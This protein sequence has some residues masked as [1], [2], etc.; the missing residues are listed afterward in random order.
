MMSYFMFLEHFFWSLLNFYIGVVFTFRHFILIN[1]VFSSKNIET[2]LIIILHEIRSLLL[3]SL[4]KFIFQNNIK[5]LLARV[6]N[7]K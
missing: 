6:V 7:I 3:W 5:F 2:N 1:D 4:T